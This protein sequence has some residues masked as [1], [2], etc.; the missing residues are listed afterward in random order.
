M[1]G[2]AGIV[3]STEQPEARGTVERMT[4]ALAR[5]GPDGNGVLD[6]GCAVLGH[7][8]LAIVDL[9][10]GAQPM[11]SSEDD[12]AMI[13]NAEIYNHAEL[14]REL[15]GYGFHCR[16]SSDVEVILHG[17]RAWGAGVTERLDGMFAFA[18][19]DG[20][21][22]SLLLARDRL[23][24]KPIYYMRQ[25][26]R[27]LFASEPKAI[28]AA[29]DTAPSIE[30]RALARYLALDFV[31]TPWCIFEG[32]H[33]LPA[34]HRLEVQAGGEP[35]IVPY[36]QL[37]L[38]SAPPG[39]IDEVT[40]RVQTLFERAVEQRLMSDVPVGL[41]LS[42][43]LDSTLVGAALRRLGV[44]LETFSLGFE[45]ADFDESGPARS[46]ASWLGTRHH[47]ER[48]GVRAL[49]SALPDIMEWLDEPFAD[50]SLLAVHVL[51]AFTRE[52]V[53]VALGGDGADEL[54]AGYDVFLAAK[55]DDWTRPAGRLRRWGLNTL[56][57]LLPVQERHFGLDFR[58]RQFARGLA[59]DDAARPTAYTLDLDEVELGQ[60]LGAARPDDVLGEARAA[61]APLRAGALDVALRQYARFFLESD[62]LFK[63]DRAGMAHG[64]EIRSP[65]LDHRLAGYAAS[66]PGRLK[67]RG[68]QRKSLLRGAL[69]RDVPRRVLKRPKQGFSLPIV[70]WINGELRGWFDDVLLDP[71][72][73]AD[74]LLERRAVEGLLA[75]HRRGEANLRKPIW[76]LAMLMLWKARWLQ[77]GSAE[78]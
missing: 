62:I 5:R 12:V 28:L 58:L 66:L 3:D 24:Q 46:V 16:T 13:A 49:H 67:L 57:R 9:A 22:Q 71:S 60:L 33:K 78:N 14:R 38:P 34:A 40:E 43:G 77:P 18:I 11:R 17:Y 56:A 54:F 31:P 35:Q 26:G 21:R 68:L 44:Q 45:E 76:N 8:R 32:I 15:A 23:G 70:R 37:P 74:G 27:F 2:I 59:Y 41:L 39:S 29:L 10:G 52:H 20:R 51:S 7:R 42:G 63:V 75:R 1:C 55:L 36:W 53:K 50:P 69:G 48:F 61:A 64:L 47:E 72:G 6:C 4:A 65:F 73:Y 30:P 19:W 25:G